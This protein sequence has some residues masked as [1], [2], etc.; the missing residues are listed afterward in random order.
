VET[1][2]DG[3]DGNCNGQID[4]AFSDLG[5]ACDNG[6]LGACRD[7]GKRVCDP[8]N[9][10]QTL[11]DLSFPPDAVPGAPHA[12]TCNGVDDDCNGVVDDGIV[13][14]M[15]HVTSGGKNF[16]VDR[17]EASRPDAT[18][19]SVGLNEARRCVNGGALPWTFTTQAEAAKACAATGARLCTAAELQVACE[20]GL[21]DLYPYGMSYQ[22]LTC[23]GLDFDG[24]AGGSNDDLLLPTGDA[25][26]N[27]CVTPTGIH[28]LSGNAAE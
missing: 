14:D 24:V 28:D 17:Y 13:D 9:P 25:R 7:V 22:P 26:L 18:A 8:G 27:A 4:E 15:V 21:A 16:Y 23:N 5:T 3:L 11:C 1:L 19:S 20:A 2:C 6:L 10:L 12:E